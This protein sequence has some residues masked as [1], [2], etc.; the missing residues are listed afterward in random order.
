MRHFSDA[1]DGEQEVQDYLLSLFASTNTEAYTIQLWS[2]HV[3]V[4][5]IE[6]YLNLKDPPEGIVRNWEGKLLIWET[7]A[8]FR[9]AD[10]EWWYLS[11]FDHFHRHHPQGDRGLA[12]GSS[13]DTP[14]AGSE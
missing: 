14:P 8:C 3:G 12:P 1:W 10:G 6:C 9:D 13:D 5:E 11:V 2:Q 4:P 7:A